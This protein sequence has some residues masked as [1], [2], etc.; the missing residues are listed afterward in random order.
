MEKLALLGGSPAICGTIPDE[1]FSW[2]IVTEEDEAAVLDVLRRRAMSARDITEKFETEFAA[3]QGRKYA[4]AYCNGTLSLQAAMFAAGLKAGDEM[5]CPS[6]T[7][8]ATAFRP[9]ISAQR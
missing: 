7:Y 9:L 5:I 8:W 2:P 6:K 3:W 4:L 1:L